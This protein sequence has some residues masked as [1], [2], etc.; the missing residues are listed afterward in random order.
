VFQISCFGFGI[1]DS[2][3]HIAQLTCTIFK[4]LMLS[5]DEYGTLL[6]NCSSPIDHARKALNH[7]QRAKSLSRSLKTPHN[8]GVP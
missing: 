1:C 7:R 4:L 6:G 2:E 3:E 5:A 8:P